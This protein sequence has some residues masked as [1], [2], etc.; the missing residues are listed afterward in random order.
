[1][2]LVLYISLLLF[3]G[4]VFMYVDGIMIYC[5]EESVDKVVELFN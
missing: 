4:I 1:M 3:I 5:I 2:L